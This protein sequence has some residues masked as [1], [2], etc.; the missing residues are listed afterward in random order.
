[1][2]NSSYRL[3][4]TGHNPRGFLSK[5]ITLGLELIEVNVEK[6][7][8]IILVDEK[9]YQKIV[10]LKT[11][12]KI[13]IINRYGLARYKY[14]FQK[15]IIFLLSIAFSLILIKALSCFILKV[16]VIHTKQEI[17]ELIIT[18]LEEYGIKPYHFK[19]SF[20]KKEQ[21]AEKILEKEKDRL[22]WMEIEEVGTTYRINVE[23]R[24]KNN[25]KI[26]KEE[27]S[28]IAKKSGRIL[29]IHA[30]HGEILKKKNDYVQKGDVIISGIIKNKETPVSK[31]RAEG[32]VFAEIW[33][34]VQVEVPYH[35]KEEIKT[36]KKKSRFEIEFLNHSYTL[37]DF[38]PY[39]ISTKERRKLLK[40]NLLPISFSYTTFREIKVKEEIH[41]AKDAYQKAQE[42]AKK[43]LKAK[44]GKEDTIISQKTLKKSHK[45]SKIVVDIF[46]KVKEN[47]TDT[48]SLKNVKLEELQ[49]KA[50]E[51]EGE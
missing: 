46:F 13:E 28:I 48:E 38:S 33:Y 18:D 35:Y 22:E 44:L 41:N 15:Y 3:K 49:E 10:D 43:K 23:E 36:G 21:I 51:K 4:I 1:M 20:S 45:N 6:N 19:V 47:I 34:Q 11:I 17:R 25:A 39:K 37:F 29:E 30:S 27:Q 31:I 26:N 5:L 40:S 9:T 8:L 2:F 7:N 42:L 32:T 24:K 16:E 12:Y 50:K 14:L